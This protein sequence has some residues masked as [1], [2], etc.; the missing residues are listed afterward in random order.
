MLGW[1]VS[2]VPNSIHPHFRKVG[3]HL[4]SRLQSS[5]SY[6]LSPPILVS[7]LPTTQTSLNQSLEKLPLLGRKAHIGRVIWGNI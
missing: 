4:L 2:N 7:V 5:P 3:C 6:P 1:W